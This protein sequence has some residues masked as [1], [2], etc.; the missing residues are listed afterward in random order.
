VVCLADQRP[1]QHRFRGRRGEGSL[2]RPYEGSWAGPDMGIVGNQHACRAFAEK[3]IADFV[4]THL[5]GY[6]GMLNVETIGGSIIEVH[7][8]FS[9]Q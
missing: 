1:Y 3:Y 4:E 9:P 8:R 5:A 6:T 2:V 7:L